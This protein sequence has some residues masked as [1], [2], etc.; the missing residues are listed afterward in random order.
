MNFVYPSFLWALLAL[1]IPIIIHLF[2]FRK[3]KKVAFSNVA[4][5]KEIKQ[6]TVSR[7]KVRHWLVLLSR[8]LLITF[9]V[10]AFA[11]PYIPVSD[12]LASDKEKIVSIYIDN[13][14]S[15][16]AVTEQGSLIQQAMDA[17]QNAVEAYGPNTLFQ[18]LTND[19]DGRHQ[20]LISKGE[21]ISLL[22]ELKIGPKTRS[23][24]DV[25][26]RQEDLILSNKDRKGEIYLISDFQ[27]PLGAIEN[28]KADSSISL[29]F[30]PLVAP[31]RANVTIDSVWFDDPIR[32][33][34]MPEKLIV[35]ISNTGEEALNQFPIIF[36]LEGVQKAL[37]NVNLAPGESV[38]DTLVF[39]PGAPGF[40]KASVEINDFPI[41]YD[42]TYNLSIEVT[43]SIKVMTIDEKQSNIYLERLFGGDDF[44]DY[45]PQ[46]LGSID[47]GEIESQQVIILSGVNS[48]S[49]GLKNSLANFVKQGGS[50]VV[51]PSIFQDKT[52]LNEFLNSLKVDEYL[53][54]VVADDRVNRL[55]KNHNLF[56]GVFESKAVDGRVD[57][58][59]VNT[60]FK[61]SQK[62]RS[63]KSSLMTLGKGDEF[64]S[65]YTIE[66]G[67][68]YLFSSSLDGKST[69]L[70]KHALFVP[71][72]YRIGLMSLKSPPVAYT[73][74]E[75][76][77]MKKGVRVRND[78]IVK[79]KKENIEIIP[80]L[81]T[82][83][84]LTQLITQEPNI[85]P[86][87]YSVELGVENLGYVAFNYSRTESGNEFVSNS[88]LA[89]YS[90]KNNAKVY[91][92][93][94]KG[95]NEKIK[96]RGLGKSLW[97]LCIILALVFATIE[98]LLL[99]LTKP[100]LTK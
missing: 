93:N 42:D 51:F 48:I 56:D 18:I 52:S 91:D 29:N 66:D 32:Q 44:F 80:E 83:G 68:V 11:R 78:E 92:G 65:V 21:F 100:I 43:S 71:I 82:F 96:D 87:I 72:L 94:G 54:L 37:G 63:S 55:N 26:S 39:T 49:S 31:D 53:E 98:I 86:G 46:L 69:N 59:S 25:V 5:L 73:I 70:P 45:S 34:D 38:M 6:E 16:E 47:Y 27:K 24:Q 75:S 61:L 12:K 33:S 2:N 79:L 13:S 1:A 95:L 40:Y 76:V 35:K 81:S 8:C 9:M 3:F 90:S 99:R 10:L 50:L 88:E 97:K 77:L 22:A 23:L 36:K 20:R 57:L 62:I 30:I 7:S 74:G 28:L 84:G 41:T 60:F 15:M 14:F 89:D 85:E 64:L 67:F 17:A 58:P 19:F 4:F